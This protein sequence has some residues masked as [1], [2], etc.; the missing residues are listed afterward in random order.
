M[1]RRRY[2][3]KNTYLKRSVA[4]VS[5]VQNDYFTDLIPCP[6]VNGTYTNY[7]CCKRDGVSTCCDRLLDFTVFGKGFGFFPPHGDNSSNASAPLLSL[8]ASSSLTS[9]PP[10]SSNVNT[11]SEPVSSLFSTT[12]TLSANRSLGL[13]T[14]S[15]K[16]PPQFN[17]YVAIGAGIGVPLGVLLLLAL[18]FLLHMEHRRRI[19]SEKALNRIQVRDKSKEKA[20]RRKFTVN[21]GSAVFE[22][23][24]SQ[25]NPME[26]H[27]GELF[28]ATSHPSPTGYDKGIAL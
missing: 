15:C 12:T 24:N 6:P 4:N 3:I 28:E 22:L 16:A 21:N 10:L 7:F 17:D 9:G 18:S 27:G 26:L 23:G 20:K 19:S 14:S 2:S 8:E 11:N 13:T 25:P 1:S 5:K